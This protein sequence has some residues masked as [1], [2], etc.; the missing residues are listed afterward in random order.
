[1]PLK[2]RETPVKINENSG[3]VREITMENLKGRRERGEKE[4]GIGRSNA[5]VVLQPVEFKGR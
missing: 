1:M 2:I 3:N 4:G 5:A